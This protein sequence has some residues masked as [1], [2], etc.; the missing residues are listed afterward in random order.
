MKE[1]KQMLSV[2]KNALRSIT[3]NQYT[4]IVA[5]CCDNGYIY[6]TVINNALSGEKAAEKQLIDRL[7]KNNATLVKKIIC[8]W[9]KD[10]VTANML[11]CLDMPSYDFRKMLCDYNSDNV[12][13]EILLSGK[14]GFITKTI[15]QTMS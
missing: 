11:D 10:E 6:H 4:Q 7:I 2:V 8:V 3:P 13:A 12:N 1:F 9:A 15:G 14:E 5:V